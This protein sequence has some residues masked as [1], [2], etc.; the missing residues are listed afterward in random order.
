MDGVVDEEELE[1]GEIRGCGEVPERVEAERG[2]QLREVVDPRRPSAGEVEAHWR[3][4]HGAYRNWC[5]VCVKA[6]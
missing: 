2:R 4:N 3:G 5:P 6:R 1:E